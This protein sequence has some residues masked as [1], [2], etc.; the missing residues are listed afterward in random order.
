MKIKRL[1]ATFGKLSR[2]VLELGEGMNIIEAPNESG[3][4]TWCAFIRAM[5]YGIK[6]REQDKIG[7]LADKTRYQPWSGESM[8]GVMRLTYA[9]RDITLQRTSTARGQ[10]K[11]F[12]AFYTGTI[13]RVAELDGDSAGEILTGA[14]EEV[15]RRSAFIGQ[16]GMKIDQ[17]GDLEKRISALV[18]SGEEQTSY[19]EAD[20]LLRKW[21]R[22]RRY[23]TSSGELVELEAERK[24]KL[25]L[26][27][28]IEDA[29]ENLASL[30]QEVERLTERRKELAADLEAHD[31]L[32]RR[33]E[34]EKIAQ[35]HRDA[36][37][38]A[39]AVAE[40]EERY[41]ALGAPSKEE[42]AKLREALSSAASL[43]LIRR[44]AE[45][46]VRSAE[47]AYDDAL[48]N[49][50]GSPL[51]RYTKE[52]LASKSAELDRLSVA[53]AKKSTAPVK[54]MVFAAAAIS[55]LC[56][57]IAYFLMPAAA[58]VFAAAAIVLVCAALL[59]RD[60]AKKAQEDLAA[61]LNDIGV[62]SPGELRA[63]AD[64][65]SALVGACEE[66][67]IAF[68]GAQMSLDSA[69]D[70]AD[71]AQRAALDTLRLYVPDAE[72]IGKAPAFIEKC[73]ELLERLPQAKYRA[74]SLKAECEKTDFRLQLSGDDAIFVRVPLRD[75][76]DT[77]DAA[78]RNDVRLAETTERYN[79]ARGTLR[80][81][82]DPMVLSGAVLALDERIDELT[83]Q[84]EALDLAINTL[85]DA[86]TEMQTRFSPMIS[87]KAGAIMKKM[88]RGKY[89]RLVFSKNFDAT[90]RLSGESIGHDA[91]FLSRGAADQVYLSLRLAIATLM[92]GEEPCP[93]ILDDALAS[94]DDE[95]MAE[96]LDLL[97]ELSQQRQ[98]I[99]FTCHKR[100]VEYFKGDS[101]VKIM[102]I[103]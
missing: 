14:S 40:L 15:F 45:S 39:S 42:L 31:K 6:T 83:A 37:A 74:D 76:E 99:L 17:T 103:D 70:A 26:L 46:D 67:E 29:N 9:D 77:I 19:S 44:N 87:E 86:N 61:L 72:S 58:L 94:F 12:D 3:K 73:E 98:V 92:P 32:D 13:E 81:M 52:E 36:S 21:Q 69:T 38:A 79:I 60:P 41:S 101:G 49:K 57:V 80:A 16:S 7:Y 59:L 51:D 63:M 68:K 20:A 78:A 56:A 25:E 2:S 10:M 30:R 53:A 90:A 95:R 33:R 24:E 1:E 84:Y 75:R 5:L 88:T 102:K 96:A 43:E 22:K 62:S 54:K 34:A 28:K 35:L 65:H 27:Q 93:I 89:D 23:K 50:T 97:K 64:E 85:K 71:R 8:Q 55:L 100:E 4:S 66:A 11:K 82:G 18:S 91:L 48:E 47:M